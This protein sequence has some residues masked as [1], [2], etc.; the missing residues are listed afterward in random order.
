MVAWKPS[1]RNCELMTRH[2]EERRRHTWKD[3]L[4]L[5]GTMARLRGGGVFAFPV[6]ILL[7]ERWLAV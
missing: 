2:V 1:H 5:A 6:V 3:R 4:F 7:L